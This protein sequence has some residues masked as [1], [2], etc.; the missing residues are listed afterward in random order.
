MGTIDTKALLGDL[1]ALS[2]CL[3]PDYQKSEMLFDQD[4]KEHKGSLFFYS[5]TLLYLMK[6]LNCLMSQTV[7]SPV[8]FWKTPELEPSFL[9]MYKDQ[10]FWQSILQTSFTK[11]TYLRF[12]LSRKPENMPECDFSFASTTFCFFTWQEKD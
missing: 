1:I 9:Y 5:R 8:P 11:V 6:P 4:R 7:P 10:K 3:L 2:K 12:L